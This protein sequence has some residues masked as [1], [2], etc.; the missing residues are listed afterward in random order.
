MRR[1]A[2]VDANQREITAALRKVGATVQPLH[3]VGRNFPDLLV[4]YRQRNY[5]LEVKSGKGTLSTGQSEWALTWRGHY[6][7]VHSVDE[8]LLAIRI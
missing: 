1:V 2:R 6:A 5:L 3:M 8:A 4:G 7:E